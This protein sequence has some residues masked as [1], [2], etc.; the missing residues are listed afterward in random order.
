M[1]IRHLADGTIYRAKSNALYGLALGETSLEG[2]IFGWASFSAKATY[3]E[4]G[5]IEPN[6]NYE[7]TVYVEDRDD[8]TL[9]PDRFWVQIHD[10]SRQIVEVMSMEEPATEYAIELVGGN[11]IVPHSGIGKQLDLLMR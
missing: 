8:T 6:G 1:I 4:P 11:I 10:K 3:I 2:E 5:W 7:F 9:G